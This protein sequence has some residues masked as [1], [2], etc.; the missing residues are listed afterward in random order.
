[1]TNDS[2]AN[3][4][5]SFSSTILPTTVILLKNSLNQKEVRVAA[6][7]H[8]DSQKP[9]SLRECILQLAPICTGRIHT[10]T[11]GNKECEI[12]RSTHFALR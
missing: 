11:F 4:I 1:M 12:L 5:S 2:P 8:Q 10:P 3:Y 6:F 9:M 7:F